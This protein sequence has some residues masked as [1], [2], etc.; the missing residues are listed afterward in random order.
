MQRERVAS[1]SREDRIIGI[2]FAALLVLATIMYDKM[3]SPYN[4]IVLL[5]L[6]AICFYGFSPLVAEIIKMS[7]WLP[8][9]RRDSM[10]ASIFMTIAV[11]LFCGAALWS[12]ATTTPSDVGSTSPT[13]APAS[14][15]PV[16]TQKATPP[17]AV[18]GNDNDVRRNEDVQG[19]PLV[20]GDRNKYFDNKRINPQ[21]K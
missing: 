8:R 13:N 11:V 10:F 9:F 17:P 3:G 2:G 7:R 19:A 5:A 21:D 1:L 12:V 6:I 15:P 16:G 4:F 18:E 20:K 14:H